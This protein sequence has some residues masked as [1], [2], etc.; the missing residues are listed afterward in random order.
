MY[1]NINNIARLQ[2]EHLLSGASVFPAEENRNFSEL[3]HENH[4]LT[5]PT[6]VK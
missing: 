1:D 5:C 4:P 2:Y 6:I 3:F